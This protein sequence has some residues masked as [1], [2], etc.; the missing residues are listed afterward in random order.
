MTPSHSRLT[1]GPLD[2]TVIR[3]NGEE[4][5]ELTWVPTL[6]DGHGRELRAEHVAAV[7][8]TYLRRFDRAAATVDYVHV[9]PGR[10]EEY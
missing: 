7:P 9:S 3:I 4:P 2:G 10:A 6:R 5:D 8:H 1:G